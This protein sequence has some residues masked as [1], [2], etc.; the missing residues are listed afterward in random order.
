VNV[1]CATEIWAE[2]D[3]AHDYHE[4]EVEGLG[5]AF[6][7]AVRYS[8]EEIKSYPTAANPEKL[9][10]KLEYNFSPLSAALR[11]IIRKRGLCRSFIGKE[12]GRR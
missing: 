3:A 9:R 2:V 5:N 7:Q 1:V 10:A 12:R 11:E 6:V 4:Q 8:V